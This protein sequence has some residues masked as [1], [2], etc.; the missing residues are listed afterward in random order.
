MSE[1]LFQCKNCGAR[2]LQ[3]V[4]PGASPVSC[5]KCKMHNWVEIRGY[6]SARPRAENWV[7]D[8]VAELKSAR[9]GM[10]RWK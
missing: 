8:F 6:T 3:T 2:V 7:D 1:R 9:R 10:L 5:P 4:T